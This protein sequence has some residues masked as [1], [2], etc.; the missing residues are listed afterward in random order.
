MMFGVLEIV[1]DFDGEW[2]SPSATQVATEARMGI[3][4]PGGRSTGMTNSTSTEYF[5]SDPNFCDGGRRVTE[6]VVA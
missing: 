4:Q 2:S 5:D 3:D 6:E 1:D